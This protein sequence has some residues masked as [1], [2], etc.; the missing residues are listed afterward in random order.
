MT[1]KVGLI[2]TGDIG[3]PRIYGPAVESDSSGRWG[4]VGK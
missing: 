1:I 4:K 3:S 2:G